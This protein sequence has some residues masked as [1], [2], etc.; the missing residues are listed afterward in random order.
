M[1]RKHE[2][3]QHFL[4]SPRIVAE[5]V[6]HSNIRKNDLVYDFGAGSG[7]IS[8]VLSE[9]A[10]EVVAIENE[11]SALQLLRTNLGERKN[12]SIIAGDALAVALP[13]KDYKVFSNPPFS[14]SSALVRRLVESHNPPKCI[15][16]IV[17]KQFAQKIMPSDRHFT[18]ALGSEIGPLYAARIRKPLRK[19]DFTPPPAVDT[20]LLELKRRDNPLLDSSELKDYREFVRSNYDDFSLFNTLDRASVGVAAQRKPSEL[21]IEQWV[22]LFQQVRP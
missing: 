1:K 13:E 21:T 19:T 14:I 11:P 5:L 9:R 20:V 7:V 12:I 6:G 18:S 22:A 3:D 15:Y 16:L 17:Q 4:R 2:Y 8:A 10:R